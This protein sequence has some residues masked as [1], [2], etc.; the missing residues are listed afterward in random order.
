MNYFSHFLLIH[1]QENEYETL[2]C[3]LPDLIRDQKLLFSN[4]FDDALQSVNSNHKH[5]S[6]GIKNHIQS[7]AIFHNSDFFKTYTKAISTAIRESDKIRINK[8]TYF[9]AH[10]LLELYIDYLLIEERSNLLTKFYKNL[11]SVDDTVLS[12]FFDQYFPQSDMELFL[13]KKDKFVSSRFLYDYENLDKLGSLISY[14]LQKVKIDR[15]SLNEEKEISTLIDTK[16][17][18]SIKND[19]DNLFL[20]M[21]GQL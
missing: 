5:L 21:K 20:K 7:D 4:E 9:V 8:Y 12:D 13:L 16:F 19:L 14:L 18:S 2:G 15:L 6:I 3:I 11:T 1:N 10:I 17:G